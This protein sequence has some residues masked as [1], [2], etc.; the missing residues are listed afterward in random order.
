VVARAFV[1]A[2]KARSRHRRASSKNAKTYLPKNKN[3]IRLFFGY[4]LSAILKP[5]ARC[6]DDRLRFLNLHR[7]GCLDDFAGFLFFFAVDEHHFT[8]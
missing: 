1:I 3:R 7:H 4:G 5:P 6:T 8:D 2:G